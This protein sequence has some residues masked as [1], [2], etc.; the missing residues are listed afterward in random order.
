MVP[1]AGGL[2]AR[3]RG[4]DEA[5]SMKGSRASSV[6]GCGAALPRR[7]GTGNAGRR[8]GHA[9]DIVGPGAVP[10]LGL[11]TQASS[12]SRA[13]QSPGARGS[14]GRP[15]TRGRPGPLLAGLQRVFQQVAGLHRGHRAAMAVAGGTSSGGGGGQ[16]SQAWAVRCGRWVSDRPAVYPARATS[17]SVGADQGPQAQPCSQMGRHR[18]LFFH[19]RRLANTCPSS[20]VSGS[21][22]WSGTELRTS[23]A[24]LRRKG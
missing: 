1:H 9:L 6:G 7:C 2:D 22:A 12:R 3:L 19:S 18:K 16:G 10:A 4:G 13:W 23:A 5:L 11:F 15:P 24:R 14:K 21:A 17:S 20:A 8:D